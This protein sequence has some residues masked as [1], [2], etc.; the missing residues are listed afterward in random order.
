MQRF[1]QR[2]RQ[3]LAGR[4]RGH[5][6]LFGR[7]RRDDAA[8]LVAGARA[9]VDDPVGGDHDLEAVR[10]R[11]QRVAPLDQGAEGVEQ[12]ED[13]DRVEAGGRLVEQEE[14]VRGPAGS[15]QG[16]ERSGQETRQLEP[17]R[18]AAGERRGRLAE[19]QVVEPDL[20]QRPEPGLDFGRWR[21]KPNASRAV[22]SRTSAMFR[23]R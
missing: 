7:S 2:P 15:A 16:G 5:G 19:P 4:R 21:K 17:L 20:E 6:D 11:D 12:L 14:R 23:P 13:V 18:L 9:Q 1:T 8:A 22:R 10:D 3:D